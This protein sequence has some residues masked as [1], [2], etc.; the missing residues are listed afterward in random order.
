MSS[1]SAFHCVQE[2]YELA[3]AA[4]RTGTVLVVDEAFIDFIPLERQSPVWPSFA[5]YS[6]DE[7]SHSPIA[8]QEWHKIWSS[9]G[10][11]SANDGQT[12]DLEC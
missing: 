3:E 2:L 1:T 12:G 9:I 10:S 6:P 8:S 5:G 7:Q 11:K 4:G